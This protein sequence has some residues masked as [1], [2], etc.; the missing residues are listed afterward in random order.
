MMGETQRSLHHSDAATSSRLHELCNRARVKYSAG[1]RGR[2]ENTCRS[3]FTIVI[4]MEQG[5]KL[6]FVVRCS[7][8][9]L[10]QMLISNVLTLEQLFRFTAGS[11]N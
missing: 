5:K 10:K 7:T 6:L 2:Y 4:S 11:E 9:A 8:S 1:C 3:S